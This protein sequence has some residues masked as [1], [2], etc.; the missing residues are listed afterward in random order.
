M[1]LLA[2]P[3]S[4]QVS[5]DTGHRS[6]DAARAE[7]G[8]VRLNFRAPQVLAA[9]GKPDS[10]SSRDDEMVGDT[11]HTWHY[12]DVRVALYGPV[13]QEIECLSRACATREGARIGDSGAAIERVYGRANPG[14][15][16]TE[17]FYY[18]IG[19]LDCSLA[20]TV[21]DGLVTKILIACD[22]S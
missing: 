3:A 10:I 20:F 5:S 2:T 14:Y 4:S 21:R 11:I 8:G 12:R 22:W 9:L 15:D 16:D 7:I 1:L 13:V 19:R 6:I 17:S 18:G